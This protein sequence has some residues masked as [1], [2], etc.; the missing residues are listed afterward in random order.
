[1]VRGK[2]RI[3]RIKVTEPARLVRTDDVLTIATPREIRVVKVIGFATRRVSAP[4][5]ATLYEALSVPDQLDRGPSKEDT[6]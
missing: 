1:M 4:E 3:N 5:T 2:V 6:A